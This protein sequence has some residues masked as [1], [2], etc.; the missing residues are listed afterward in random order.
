M[1]HITIS[2]DQSSDQAPNQLSYQP[3]LDLT[4][5][6]A[7][8]LLQIS[9]GVEFVRGVCQAVL[10]MPA[11]TADLL[12]VW[13]GELQMNLPELEAGESLNLIR[14]CRNAQLILELRAKLQ[15]LHDAQ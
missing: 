10:S 3:I 8:Q 6:Q 13:A 1:S 5:A 15:T 2:S 7:D 14:N 4:D 11:E 12:G 9:M